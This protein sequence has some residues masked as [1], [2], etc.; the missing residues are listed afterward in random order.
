MQSIFTKGVTARVAT[1]YD[2]IGPEIQHLQRGNSVRDGSMSGSKAGA[3]AASIALF[4]L[5]TLFFMDPFLFAMHKSSAIRAY[6]Y[7]HNY[8]SA[9]STEA[10]VSSGIF[11]HADV[12]EMNDKRGSYQDYFASAMDAEKT[13]A[14]AVSFMSGMHDL[15][16]AQ[17]E[18]LDPIGKLRYMLFVRIG[19]YPPTIWSG[20]NPS[21]D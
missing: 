14:S 19:L 9:A 10:L 7:L 18:T 20:L 15:R 21:V 1:V 16:Y 6:I 12:N 17:P 8:G 3:W 4:L 13:A 11:S 5:L 2:Q